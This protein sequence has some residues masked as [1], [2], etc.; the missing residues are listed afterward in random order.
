MPF[1]LNSL[2]DFVGLQIEDEKEENE[3]DETLMTP[4]LFK[5]NFSVGIDSKHAGNFSHLGSMTPVV[6]S[7]KPSK[8]S[9]QS[10]DLDR[11]SSF[12]PPDKRKQDRLSVGH[13]PR[14]QVQP[15]TSKNFKILS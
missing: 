3:L 10:Q 8:D 9:Q 13:L 14:I 4:P 2:D 6:R 11:I 12:D 7:V 5:R 1:R 15:K